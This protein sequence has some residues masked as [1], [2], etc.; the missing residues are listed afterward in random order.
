VTP[1]NFIVRDHTGGQPP[2]HVYFEDGPS[3]KSAVN[4]SRRRAVEGTSFRRYLEEL[5]TCRWQGCLWRCLLALELYSLKAFSHPCFV[6]LL[7]AVRQGAIMARDDAETKPYI[8]RGLGFGQQLR[9]RSALSVK[10][11]PREVVQY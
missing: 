1:N 5:V 11:Y 3:W 7:V 8:G 10:P 6:G 9:F 4:Y 2:A